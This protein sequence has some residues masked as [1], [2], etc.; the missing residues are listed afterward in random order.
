MS[1][2]PEDATMTF[3]EHL[4]ELRSRI[5]RML[6]AFA[7][8]ASVAWFF[9]ETLLHWLTA[10]FVRAW[11][12]Q[13][14]AGQAALHFPAPASLFVAY[15]KLSLLG[16]VVLSLPVILYQLW[17]FI[18]PGLYS[19]EKRLAIPFVVSSCLLFA[20]GGYFGWRVAFPIA[21]QYLLGFSGP[22]GTDFEVKPTVMIGDYI[23]FVTRMLAAFGAVFELPVLIFFLSVAGLVTHKHLI[24]FA[25]YFVVISFV[26]AA[27]I[28]PPDVT[29]QFL[30]AVPLCL[31]YVVSIGISWLV[32]F[33]RRK[34]LAT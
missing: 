1:A 29:S 33:R 25:R 10:P 21:F 4:A 17:A 31:L 3:W 16:G 12:D 15:I 19:S 22:V 5:L 20:A 34:R 13:H 27:I 26:L 30:L 23:E 8:G 18:A 7:I 6:L 11:N 9:R 24:R 32:D 28:T 14:L 2:D